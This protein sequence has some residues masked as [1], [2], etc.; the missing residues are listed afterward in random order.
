MHPS[1]LNNKDDVILLFNKYYD[2]ICMGSDWPE[3]DYNDIFD[4]IN[5]LLDKLPR[6]KMINILN[7][8]IKRI[9]QI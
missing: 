5:L 6:E 8:N 7:G 4:R 2:R 3:F 9:F 1:L